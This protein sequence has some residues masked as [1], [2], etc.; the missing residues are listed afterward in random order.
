MDAALVTAFF[1]AAI[2]IALEYHQRIGV[3]VFACLT[4]DFKTGYDLGEIGIRDRAGIE[5]IAT[6][7]ELLRAAVA[8]YGTRHSARSECMATRISSAHMG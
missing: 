4:L 3:E 8:P 2:V 7:A 6:Q 5:T 1:A